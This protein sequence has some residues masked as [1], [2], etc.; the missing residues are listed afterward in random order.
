ML[1]RLF[2]PYLDIYWVQFHVSVQV[3][4]RMRL[5]K[6]TTINILTAPETEYIVNQR[7]WCILSTQFSYG[8]T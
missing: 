6:Q 4:F 8:L 3:Q 2:I 5:L 7:I 1:V